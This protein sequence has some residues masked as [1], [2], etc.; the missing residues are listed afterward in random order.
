MQVNIGKWYK[1]LNIELA[2]NTTHSGT[3]HTYGRETQNFI[4]QT[5]NRVLKLCNDGKAFNSTA[6][7]KLQAFN[8]CQT[9]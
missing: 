7:Q 6:L 9:C 2:M 1:Q 4:I 8:K 5:L 3:R